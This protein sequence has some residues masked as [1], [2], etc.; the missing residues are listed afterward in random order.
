MAR[1]YPDFFGYSVFPGPGTGASSGGGVTAVA[2]GATETLIEL[3]LK[4]SVF[5]GHLYGDDLGPNGL[6]NI[7]VIVDGITID[8]CWLNNMYL[9]GEHHDTGFLLALYYYNKEDN[10]F[11]LRVVEDLS[12]GYQFKLACQNADVNDVNMTTYIYYYRVV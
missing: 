4:G 2:A 10:D 9:L 11:A 1:G 6:Y 7:R 5:G 8:D 3:N 12:F